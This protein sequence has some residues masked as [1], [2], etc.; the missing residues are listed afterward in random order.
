MSVHSSHP[1]R[2]NKEEDGKRN[3]LI[4]DIKVM[5]IYKNNAEIMCKKHEVLLWLINQWLIGFKFRHKN[6][7]NKKI[8]FIKVKELNAIFLKQSFWLDYYCLNYL[9]MKSFRKSAWINLD[10]QWSV[11]KS[12]GKEH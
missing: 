12:S 4:N 11:L 5:L 9:K 7:K 6:A 8:N 2:W 1:H 10:H 3:I